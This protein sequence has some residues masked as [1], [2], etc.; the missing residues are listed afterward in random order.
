MMDQKQILR[1]LNDERWAHHRAKHNA[2]VKT[3]SFQPGD[4]ILCHCHCH[5]QVQRERSGPISAKLTY[6]FTGP[7]IVLCETGS[8]RHRIQKIRHTLNQENRFG[9]P[10]EE[11]AGRLVKIPPF[12]VIHWPVQGTYTNF[13]SLQAGPQPHALLDT[14]GI[15]G[16]RAIDVASWLEPHQYKFP[17]LT[18][19]K[20]FV[21][22]NYIWPEILWDESDDDAPTASVLETDIWIRPHYSQK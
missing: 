6:G 13:Y 16:Y 15:V 10:R 17:S 19:P 20:P 22:L 18:L 9:Q 14:L 8:T 4:I 5:C 3:R 2:L 1:V 12:L 7:F 11:S 21:A